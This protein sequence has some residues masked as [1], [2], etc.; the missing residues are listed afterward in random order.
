MKKQLRRIYQLLLP[1]CD[2]LQ[3]IRGIYNYPWYIGSWRRYVRMPGAE[4]L[5]AANAFP[6]VHDRTATTGVDAHYFYNTGWAMRR[7]LAESPAQ[8]IDIGSHNTFVN[9]LSSV[10]P[11]TFVDYR[12]LEVCMDGL[13][14]KAGDILNLPFDDGSVESLSCLHVAEHIGLGRYGDPLNPNGTQ[15]ACAELSRVLSPG[16][17]LFFALPVGKQRVCFNAHR[18]HAA[19][20]VVEYFKELELV[21][22]SGVHDDGKYVERVSLDEFKDSDYAC[23]LFWFKCKSGKK[24]RQID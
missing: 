12:P 11:V 14:N 16:G 8:H 20:T 13:T 17:N 5:R 24:G 2:P 1:V 19:E 3:V 6:Q 10:L 23:G 7:I 22:F 9:L 15:E 21:E 4:A 18:I